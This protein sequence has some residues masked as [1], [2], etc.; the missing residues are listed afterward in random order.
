M[1]KGNFILS[2]V[3]RFVLLQS[4][5]YRRFHCVAHKFKACFFVATINF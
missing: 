2:F 1:Y 4:V 5:L 3:E